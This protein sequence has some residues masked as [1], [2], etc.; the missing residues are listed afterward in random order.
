MRSDA[1][2]GTDATYVR[3]YRPVQREE[4]PVRMLLFVAIP[5]VSQSKNNKVKGMSVLESPTPFP[6]ALVT[7]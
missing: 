4:H 3:D 1:T 5:N 6:V 7:A 2:H